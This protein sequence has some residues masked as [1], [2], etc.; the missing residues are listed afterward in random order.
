[1]TYIEKTKKLVAQVALLAKQQKKLAGFTIGNTAKVD[2]AGLY[3]TPLRQTTLMVSAGVIVYSERQAI[4]A[5][6]IA[7]GRV[8][9]ILVDAEK[10]VADEMSCSGE[11][12]NV[13]RAV[14]EH[15]AKSTLWIYKGNDLAVE[16]VDGLITELTKTQVQGVGG[17]KVAILGAGN[18]GCKLALKIVERGGHVYMTRRNRK[19][20]DIIVRALNIIKPEHTIA[21]AH[22]LVDNEKAAHGADILIGASQGTPLIN[23]KIIRNLNADPIVIDVGKGTLDHSALNAAEEMGIVVYRL[24]IAAAFEGLI[25]KL[26]ATESNVEQR[27][28]RR[29]VNGIRIVAGGILGRLGEIV[30]DNIHT[31]KI[32]YGI[33]N[34]YGDFVRKTTAAQQKDMRALSAKIKTGI[35]A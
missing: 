10:K 35:K 11:P 6:K 24:D 27:M 30:V 14:R 13:E 21:Q 26:W 16:A 22:G 8:D 34:G 25:Y 3:F 12:A 2:Q 5:A 20:L 18:L 17:K 7:D 1:M 28:G 31:P 19:K 32:I 23:E 29:T 9:Y 15:I 33:A 4:E